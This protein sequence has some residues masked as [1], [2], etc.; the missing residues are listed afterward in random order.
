MVDP[1]YEVW[2]PRS[3]AWLSITLSGVDE[4][5]KVCPHDTLALLILTRFFRALSA[6]ESILGPEALDAR[7][8]NGAKAEAPG[9]IFVA[10][11]CFKML[12]EMVELELEAVLTGMDELACLS[13]N[14]WMEGATAGVIGLGSGVITAGWYRINIELAQFLRKE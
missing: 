9:C 1:Q 2:S 5:Y 8:P 12:G 11:C 6:L 10:S 3:F 7:V 13:F 14:K 4:I